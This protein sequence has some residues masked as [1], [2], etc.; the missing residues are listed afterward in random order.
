MHASKGPHAHAH[1]RATAKRGWNSWE[2]ASC[3]SR[4]LAKYRPPR[5]SCFL[6]HR[7]VCPACS[8]LFPAPHAHMDTTWL[9]MRTCTQ[10][11][12]ACMQHSTRPR[13]GGA[14]Q[15]PAAC[16]E[17]LACAR[18]ACRSIL[19]AG[20][21]LCSAPVLV[22]CETVSTL[23]CFLVQ[24]CLPPRRRSRVLSVV[25]VFYCVGPSVVG[26]WKDCSP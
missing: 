13:W 24:G 1:M 17:Y 19:V 12:T 15:G 8:L 3:G 18:H 25:V 22:Q 9:C 16:C 11:D 4:G 10:H 21:F 7:T 5:P 6:V 23:P 2:S 20:G 26:D 14:G